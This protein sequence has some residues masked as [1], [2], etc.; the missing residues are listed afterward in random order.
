MTKKDAHA[1][2][3]KNHDRILINKFEIT[4]DCKAEMF[5]KVFIILEVNMYQY[6]GKTKKILTI[7]GFLIREYNLQFK[8]QTFS[9]YH[10]FY[11]P[12][13]T[14]SFYNEFGCFTLHNA[15]Q[16]G[17]WGLYISEKFSEDQ[18]KLMA[19]EIYDCDYPTKWHWTTTGWLKDLAQAIKE[20]IDKKGTMLGIRV[21]KKNADDQGE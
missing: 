14:Y 4:G 6:E 17:E 3:H 15:V 18:Y 5:G 13:D 9:M 1:R 2:N 19:R 10:N 11:G 7:F 12:M 20:E 21:E 8:F 16:R